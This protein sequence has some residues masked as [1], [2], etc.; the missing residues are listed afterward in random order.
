M[1]RQ[2][3][4]DNWY[5][6][7]NDRRTDLT[8]DDLGRPLTHLL[9]TDESGDDVQR[10]FNYFYNDT[11]GIFTTCGSDG[12]ATVTT[13][14]AANR[15]LTVQQGTESAAYTYCA[16]GR[17]ESV[18]YS[19]GASTWYTYDFENLR[20]NIDHYNGAATPQMILGLEY[21]FTVNGL[22]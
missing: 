21:A 17:L 4:P 7:G 6:Y 11:S 13:L 9:T 16:D 10:F 2:F 19:N 20:M 12:T 22:V 15:P 5:G 1:L 18:I 3:D 8:Y 14:D